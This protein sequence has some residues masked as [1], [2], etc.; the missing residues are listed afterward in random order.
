MGSTV[1]TTVGSVAMFIVVF[2]F[3]SLFY[4][5]LCIR[6]FVPVSDTVSVP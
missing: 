5:D 2:I 4:D 6:V 1:G 3:A